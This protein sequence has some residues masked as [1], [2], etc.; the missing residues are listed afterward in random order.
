VR[1][2]PV[3]VTQAAAELGVSRARVHAL[4]K[5]GRLAAAKLGNQYVI[6]LKDLAK[7]RDR[8][9]GRPPKK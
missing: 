2:G 5:V 4:I 8:K 7:V 3:T 6:G 1:R 9:P